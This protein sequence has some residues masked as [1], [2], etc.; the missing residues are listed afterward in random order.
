MRLGMR[1]PVPGVGRVVLRP[2]VVTKVDTSWSSQSSIRVTHEHVEHPR[3]RG[4]A[5]RPRQPQPTTLLARSRHQLIHGAT[6]PRRTAL[7][8]PRPQHTPGSKP[9]PPAPAASKPTRSTQRPSPQPGLPQSGRHGRAGPV[10]SAGGGSG[11]VG[12]GTAAAMRAVGNCAGGDGDG[13]L[14]FGRPAG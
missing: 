2:C 4:Q 6:I 11:T 9:R 10:R 3:C 12:S 5:P 8:E 7:S 14:A 1:A 13:C